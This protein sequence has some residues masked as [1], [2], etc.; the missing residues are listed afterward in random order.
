M[1]DRAQVL[2]DAIEKIVE[3]FV[4]IR[5][6]DGVSLREADVIDDYGSDEE[7]AAAR[8]R[9]EGHEWRKIR[10][11]DLEHN[12]FALCFMDEP[13][14]L[15]HLPAFMC[16]ALR[17]PESDSL[18]T[19]AA[20]SRLCDS[21]CI[22]SLRSHLTSSQVDAIVTFLTASLEFNDPELPAIVP[23]SIRHWLGDSGAGE[24][25]AA[26]KAWIS[27]TLEKFNAGR[28][29]DEEETIFIEGIGG[30]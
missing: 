6:G 26:K 16:Y 9:D 27:T 20:T 5:L 11:V 21:D 23:L 17:Y 12:S 2:D 19:D 18:S 1:T 10:K 14:L 4:D 7:R 30:G 25:L 15:F 8:E 28:V 22:D 29:L 13:G 24:Q 3:A